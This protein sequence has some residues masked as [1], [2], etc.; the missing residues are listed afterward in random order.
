MNKAEVLSCIETLEERIRS[1]NRHLEGVVTEWEEHSLILEKEG[2]KT[3]KS[4][5]S[6][7][8]IEELNKE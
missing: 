3:G 7:L 2:C 8:L 1:I 5:L 6:E 4:T